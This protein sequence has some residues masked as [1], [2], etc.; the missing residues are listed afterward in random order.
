MRVIQAIAILALLAVAANAQ[1][2]RHFSAARSTS[3]FYSLSSSIAS[4]HPAYGFIG[5]NPLLRSLFSHF[6]TN[7]RYFDFAVE[8]LLC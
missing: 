3:L 1:V 2:R 4:I 7:M 8:K 6:G 5:V